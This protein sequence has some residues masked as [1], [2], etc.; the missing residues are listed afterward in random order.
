MYSKCEK[1]EKEK[2]ENKTHRKNECESFVI[3]GFIFISYTHK[4]NMMGKWE[5]EMGMSIHSV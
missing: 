1:N 4:M 5:N 3:F 2:Y